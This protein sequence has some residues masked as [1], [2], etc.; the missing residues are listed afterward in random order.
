MKNNFSIIIPT[1]KRKEYVINLLQSLKGNVPNNS[2][3]IIVE[4]KEN[5]KKLFQEVVEKIGLTFQYIFMPYPSM[6]V[7]RNK[8][9]EKAKAD[10]VLFLDDDCLVQS[11][12]REAVNEFKDPFIGAVVGKA[13]VE[14]EKINYGNVGKVT[15]WGN[16]TNG[17]TSDK[18]QEV[19]S[20]IGCHM[21]WRKSVFE[22]VGLF[23]TQFSGNALREESDMS[24]RAREA[25]YKII[26]NPSVSV[27][28]VR[29]DS[30]GARKTEGRI[31]WYFDFFS[32]EAYFF[33]KHWPFWSV[34][35]IM[36]TRWEWA[37][38]CMFGFGRE[39]SIRSIIT[40]FTGMF[41]GYKKYRR[42][43]HE[44]RY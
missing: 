29:A 39:V 9:I 27:L 6:T 42:W 4:Q 33:L 13:Y 26:Y 30:G 18:R 22:K 21:Y 12:L 11:S 5:N 38:R 40:P 37:L 3:I 24:F 7:A 31:Q 43:K 10:I 8:G 16:F 44:N 35:L 36:L 17:F 2:E 1:Y 14:G 19:D 34:L 23:D 32:N 15:W 20:V 25:G 28:H 41:D